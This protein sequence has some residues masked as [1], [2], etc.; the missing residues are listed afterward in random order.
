MAYLLAL[1]I[2]VSCRVASTAGCIRGADHAF[3]LRS[4]QV[5]ARMGLVVRLVLAVPGRIQG[6]ARLQ[7]RLSA[8]GAHRDSGDAGGWYPRRFVGSADRLTTVAHAA[9]EY[10]QS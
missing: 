9:A 2:T 4:L 7:A 10:A 6:A 1:G 8:R 5:P 3:L